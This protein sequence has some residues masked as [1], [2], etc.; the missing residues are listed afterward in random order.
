MRRSV[1]L[2]SYRYKISILIKNEQFI[3]NSGFANTEGRFA[4]TIIPAFG[5]K[6]S[7]C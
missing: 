5:F 3:L 4:L 7:T 6:I 2:L 1:R